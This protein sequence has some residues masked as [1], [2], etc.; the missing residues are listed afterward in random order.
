[1][2]D[3]LLTPQAIAKERTNKGFERGR[4]RDRDDYPVVLKL[5]K[6]VAFF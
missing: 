6:F 1:M 4:D 5:N 2:D 3:L